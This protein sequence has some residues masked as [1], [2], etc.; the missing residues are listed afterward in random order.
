MNYYQHP[1][2]SNSML[3]NYEK[4]LF[5][6]PSWGNRNFANAFGQLVHCLILEKDC[7]C[8]DVSMLSINE[9][10]TAK[11][12][13]INAITHPFIKWLRQWTSKEKEIYWSE[14]NTGLPCKSKIDS[15]FKK[16]VIDLKT[17]TAKTEKAFRKSIIDFN[18]HRQGAFYVD[19]VK[20]HRFIIVGLQKQAPFAI[21]KIEISK[22]E[23]QDG[24]KK[25][26]QL[27]KHGFKNGHFDQLLTQ[28]LNH[29]K[30]N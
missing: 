24:R 28:N 29:E 15:L 14:Q 30:G 6:L 13:A 16:T 26:L 9:L 23:L 1:A 4:Q 19:S 2:I 10:E 17:T 20:A 21:W 18:Y 27:L 25:Y 22:A 3:S 8:V 7:D 11:F 12:V 5:N